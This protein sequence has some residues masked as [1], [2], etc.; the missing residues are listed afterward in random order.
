MSFWTAAI[1]DTSNTIIVD[2][3]LSGGWIGGWQAAIPFEY[4][5]KDRP[6]RPADPF[7]VGRVGREL[8]EVFFSKLWI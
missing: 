6:T 8:A 7:H 1:S 3:R 2:S 5:C 4:P